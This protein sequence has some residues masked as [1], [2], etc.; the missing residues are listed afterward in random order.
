M[1]VLVTADFYTEFELYETTDADDLKSWVR[2][3]VNGRTRDLDE[4]K[5]RIIASHETMD[6]E[7]AIAEADPIIYMSDLDEDI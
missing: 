4:T 1:K 6:T 2:D 5:H 7:T 3:M